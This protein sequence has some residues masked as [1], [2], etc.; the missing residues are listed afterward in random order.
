MYFAPYGEK[1]FCSSLKKKQNSKS[2]IAV[3]KTNAAPDEQAIKTTDGCL[4]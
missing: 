1:K 3:Y 2:V 4:Q